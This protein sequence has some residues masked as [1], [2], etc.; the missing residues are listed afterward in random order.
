MIPGFETI[1]EERIK[2]AQKQ[3]RFDNLQGKG[4]PLVFDDSPVPNDL[5]MAHKILKNSGFLPPE[6]EIR[7]QMDQVREL[8]DHAEPAS[9]EKSKLHKKLN[10]LMAKLDAVRSTGP[11]STLVRGQYR[12]ALLRKIK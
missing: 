6:I 2:A 12:T 1:V 11:G 7:K 4:K 3:G 10:Y 9:T 8:M 5:R